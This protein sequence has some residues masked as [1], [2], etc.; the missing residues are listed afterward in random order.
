MNKLFPSNYSLLLWGLAWQAPRSKPDIDAYLEEAEK[1]S[2][3]RS[4]GGG[5]FRALYRRQIVHV[6]FEF[7]V[8]FIVRV[9]VS[10]T[11]YH[12]EAQT[13]EGTALQPFSQKPLRR[14]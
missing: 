13:P 14:P 11:T 2:Q 7:W 3:A 6:V 12:R 1:S 4:E 8:A 10:E 9:L 5:A